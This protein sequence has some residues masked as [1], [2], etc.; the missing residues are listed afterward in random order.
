M[1]LLKNLHKHAARQTLAAGQRAVPLTAAL[2]MQ[3]A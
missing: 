3:A 2:N 1:M